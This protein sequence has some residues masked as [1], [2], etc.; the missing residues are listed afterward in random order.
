MMK[1]GDKKRDQ[2]CITNPLIH[3][4]TAS[5]FAAYA[6]SNTY[7]SD[8]DTQTVTRLLHHALTDLL[9]IG[10]DL[11]AAVVKFTLNRHVT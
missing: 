2:L 7:Y 5:V 3:A 8:I 11:T 6:K 10:N 4:D 1:I 9:E